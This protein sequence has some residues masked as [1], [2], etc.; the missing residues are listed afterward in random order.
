MDIFSTNSLFSFIRRHYRSLMPFLTLAKLKN[1]LMALLEMVFY[2]TRCR[3]RPFIYRIDPCTACNIKCPGC[4]AHTQKTTEKRLMDL[5]VFQTIIDKIKGYGIRASLYDT[6]EPLLN[7]NIYKMI[8]YA[9]ANT[10]STSISTN[11]NLFNKDKHLNMLF[12]SGLTVLQPDFDGMSQE[13]YSKYRIGGEISVVKDG[14]EAVVQHKKETGAKY[15]IIEPQIIMFEH[16]MHEKTDINHYLRNVGVDQIT[17]KYDTWG[18][19]PA[20]TE[21]HKKTDSKP[22]RCFWL[23]VGIMIRPDGNVYPCCG[24]GF[25]RQPYGNILHQTIDEIWNNEYYQFS[26]QLFMNG[27]PLKYNAKMESLPCHDCREFKVYRTML[28][29]PKMPIQHS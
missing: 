23:Y 19:N 25:D 16:L 24:R 13:V 2:R 26:R 11:F 4:E 8:S 9:T 12:E 3:S 5:H 1:V 20:K 6:G 27:P 21:G 15:P 29:K 28:A 7:K 10:I 17:W 22:K 14:I 18:F